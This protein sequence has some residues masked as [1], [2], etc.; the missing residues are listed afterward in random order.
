MAFR[1]KV[2]FAVP[3]R[4]WLA[5]EKFNKQIK[6]KLL[7]ETSKK[8]FNQNEL[9]SLWTRYLSG[10]EFLWSRIYAIYAF[11]IWYDIKLRD[12]LL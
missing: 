12:A 8:F 4:K 9:E 3:V 5:D 2:G 11:L 7:G 6:E 10:E 1:K